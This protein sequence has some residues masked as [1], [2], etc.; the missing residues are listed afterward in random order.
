MTIVFVGTTLT[1]SA[2]L[3]DSSDD[4]SDNESDKDFADEE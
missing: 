3:D 2:E 1:F 4:E